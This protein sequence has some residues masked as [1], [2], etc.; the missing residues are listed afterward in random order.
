[1]HRAGRPGPA[2]GPLYVARG[3]HPVPPAARSPLPDLA[4]AG[5]HLSGRQAGEHA[6]AAGVG[7]LLLT[8]VPPWFDAEEIRAEAAEAFDGPVEVVTADGSY[9]V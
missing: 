4:S 5:V 1:M 3:P 9:G 8:H 7:A 6:G 2:P